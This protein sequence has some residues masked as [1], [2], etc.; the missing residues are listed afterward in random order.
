MRLA[1][2][3]LKLSTVRN[4]FRKTKR[5]LERAEVRVLFKTAAYVTTTAQNNL[6]KGGRSANLPRD[7]F[8]ETQLQRRLPRTV[9]AR[10]LSR[11]LN[12]TSKRPSGFPRRHTGAYRRNLRFHVYRNQLSA[13]S[14]P[15]LF[16]RWGIPKALEHGGISRRFTRSAFEPAFQ[17]TRQYAPMQKTLAMNKVQ[18][19]IR[20]IT[21]RELGRLR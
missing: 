7:A 2:A 3:T 17:R 18:V 21:Y 15:T 4:N 14:G 11:R 10:L 5:K 16:K 1:R 20:N 6:G 13:I 8:T 19:A 12:R 9:R